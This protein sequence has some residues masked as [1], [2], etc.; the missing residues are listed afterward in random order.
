[1]RRWVAVARTPCS[2][3][4]RAVTGVALIVIFSASGIP[5]IAQG[6]SSPLPMRRSA[7]VPAPPARLATWISAVAA[8]QPGMLDDAV[9][10]IAPWTM[11]ELDSVLRALVLVRHRLQRGH[12]GSFEDFLVLPLADPRTGGLNRLLKRAALLHADIAMAKLEVDPHPG[13]R[14]NPQIVRFVDGRRRVRLSYV[15][16]AFGRRLLD[17]IEPS[18]RDD[19]DVRLW[20]LAAGAF[21][22]SDSTLGDQHVTHALEILPR[23][24]DNLFYTA[25][26]HEAA[27]APAVQRMAR[28]A[29]A[30]SIADAR[31]EQE[32]AAALFRRALD[33]NPG[34]SEARIRL[35]ALLTR[36]GRH[37]AAARELHRALAGDPDPLAAHY[38]ELLL[39][40]VLQALRRP[41]DAREAYLRAA[42]LQPHAQAPW[43]AISQLAARLGDREGAVVA[44]AEVR[45]RGDAAE[46]RLE[47]WAGYYEAGGRDLTARLRDLRAA[48]AG[49]QSR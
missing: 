19:P 25:C 8:H 12:T 15:H 13:D 26:L 36:M 16:W 31:T 21:M 5:A 44:L 11:E 22:V 23:D 29:G 6:L 14:R 34:H 46:T 30:A 33:R 32:A 35:A 28:Q 41:A 40:N 3:R 47:P 39:G 38:G 1:M 10:A 37:E 17:A 27:S 24:A 7:P 18:P 49:G 4:L 45:L 2:R 20:Y 9:R 43:L 42:A 48:V